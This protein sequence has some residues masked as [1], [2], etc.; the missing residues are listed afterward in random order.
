MLFFVTQPKPDPL[1]DFSSWPP[2]AGL[3]FALLPY[4]R[5]AYNTYYEQVWGERE[6]KWLEE[7]KPRSTSDSRRD[8]G[9]ELEIGMDNVED[10]EEQGAEQAGQDGNQAHP[11]NNPPLDQPGAPGQQLPPGIAGLG[12]RQ[13]HHHR[14]LDYS[15]SLVRVAQSVIGALVFPSISA[16]M[17]DALRSILP[18]SWTQLPWLKAKP[19][20]FLQTRWGR[21]IVGGC[22]FVVLKDAVTLYVKWKM[23]QNHRHRS[24][25]DYDKT[26]KKVKG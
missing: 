1:V 18:V 14:R 5:A 16:V 10:V 21:S 2:S 26:K 23:A 4:A 17:G 12:D 11:L 9:F 20:R 24:V 25:V 6:R 7:V 22:L 13:Q 15:I 3:S 19:T 8:D